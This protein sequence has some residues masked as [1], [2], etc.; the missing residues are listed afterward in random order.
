MPSNFTKTPA[1]VIFGCSGLTLSEEE[2]S[3]FAKVNPL[4]FILFARNIDNPEQ[5]KK[6]VDD[7]RKSI[8]R[9]DAPVLIDQ[10]GGRVARLKEP[11]WRVAP[12]AKVFGDMAIKKGVEYACSA[13]KLNAR[14]FAEELKTLGI[15][16]D[17]IPVLDV[18]VEGAHDIIGNRAYS[19]DAKLNAKLGRKTCEGLMEGGV[20]PVI[21]HIPGHGRSDVDSHEHLPQVNATLSELDKTD[22]LPFRELR[23]APIAM[24][25]H[26]VYTAIDAKKPA[27]LSRIVIGET[28][29]ER[30]EY[31]GFILS[32]DLS[33][34][35]L[36]GTLFERAEAALDA[37]CDA[38]LHCN[39]EMEEMQE[40]A[41]AVK[42]LDDKSLARWEKAQAKK[43]EA[44]TKANSLA[45]ADGVAELQS[46]IG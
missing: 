39:G 37:G 4:G 9:N 8:N 1:A 7:L 33:M 28:I 17:C 14:L 32:D 5:V 2:K 41:K 44:M 24:T 35:A 27:T 15:D 29:R 23:D 42:P 16:V 46:M 22:F 36:S 30:L 43:L 20:L 25:A 13:V 6:L 3:F 34:K 21:K 19:N 38:L 12:P 40:V 18:P 31:E 45:F 11:H 26:V 10:E